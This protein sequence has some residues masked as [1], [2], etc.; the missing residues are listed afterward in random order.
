MEMEEDWAGKKVANRVGICYKDSWDLE[1]V[2]RMAGH[3][4]MLDLKSISK[5]KSWRSVVGP[6]R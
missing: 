5:S 3:Q 4:Y 2:Q 6:E 1:Q